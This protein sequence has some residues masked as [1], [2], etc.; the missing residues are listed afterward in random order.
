MV[1]EDT[2]NPTRTSPKDGSYSWFVLNIVLLIA[3]LI[4]NIQTVA[5]L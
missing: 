5:E 1:P 2:E 3:T 4:N